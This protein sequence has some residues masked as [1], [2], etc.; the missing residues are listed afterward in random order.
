MKFRR[1]SSR[2]W[3]GSTSSNTGGIS[4]DLAEP[5]SKRAVE[6]DGTSLKPRARVRRQR[7]HAFQ[8]VCCGVWL[9][10][11]HVAFY[12]WEDRSEQERASTGTAEIGIHA[13]LSP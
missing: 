9:D 10:G 12:E 11:T 7:S 8:S 1:C 13:R 5:E 4:L 2:I 6:V 3:V